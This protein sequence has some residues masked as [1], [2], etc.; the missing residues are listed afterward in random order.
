MAPFLCTGCTV[1]VSGMD[2]KERICGCSALIFSTNDMIG[3][4]KG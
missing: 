1:N 4:R 2:A 3:S